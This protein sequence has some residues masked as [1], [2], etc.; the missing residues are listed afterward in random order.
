[1]SGT[2]PD[3][4]K[5]T[6][7][8]LGVVLLGTIFLLPRFVDKPWVAGDTDSLPKVPSGSNS[9]VAP[10]TA[11]E[12][13][14]FRQES[15]SVLA[16]V[17][18]I[19]D[20]LA[21]SGVEKWAEVEFQQSLKRIEAGDE[22][23]SYG[24][25]DESLG[26]YRQARD[27]LSEIENLGQQK[28]AGAK[29]EAEAAIESLNIIT[30]EA[31]IGLAI[32]IAPQDQAVQALAARIETLADLARHMEAGDEALARDQYREAQ[33]AYRKAVEID[34]K[35]KRATESL[36]EA[37]QEVRDSVFRAHM[38]RGFAALERQDFDGA[39][40]AFNDAGKSRP[41]D[42]AVR[43]ALEQAD[44]REAGR[45]VSREIERAAELEA[46][47]NWRQ[48]ATIYEELL[49]QDPSL[50]DARVRLIPAKVRAELDERMA[51]YIADPLLM[52][53]Q[54]G[55]QSAQ[56]ALADANGIANPGPRL[57]GQIEQLARLLKFA[58]SPV[59]VVFSSDNKT[60]VILYRVA[61]LGQFDQVSVKLRPGKYVA[62]G[63]RSG[64]RDVRVEF[65][66]TGESPRQQV[67]VRCEDPI[68]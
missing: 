36:A 64:F 19:R 44:N 28:L 49:K 43:K 45:Y 47:E 10:S 25:Y 26:L 30:A 67:V 5:F 62:A 53:S 7:L 39:R 33:A 63:T 56:T 48:A 34:P 20:R 15:Q 52:S 55:Y 61:E 1:M 66:V 22:R 46:V 51:G 11:A 23:Y 50:T 40:Y 41:G 8:V 13:T 38:S 17:M 18:A 4:R 12:L 54:S 37:N 6:L 58:N 3:I 60:N 65:T 27:S 2:G 35:H 31:A 16:E 21:Q 57:A 32:T 59:D 68:S 24:D 29:T 42:P 9:D 14:R